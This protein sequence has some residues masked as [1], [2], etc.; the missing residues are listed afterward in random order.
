MRR[1]IPS[2][3]LRVERAY[4]NTFTFNETVTL[5]LSRKLGD[6]IIEMH[7]CDMN[8]FQYFFQILK[9]HGE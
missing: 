2:L 1:L 9:F 6:G 5:D 7:I 3:L 8:P 4:D